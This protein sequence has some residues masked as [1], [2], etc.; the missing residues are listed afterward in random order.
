VSSPEGSGAVFSVQCSVFSVQFSV[1][2]VQ[3]SVF[4]LEG[5]G[6]VF[7]VQCSVFS[8]QCS[9]FSVQCSVFSVQ[10]SVFSVQCSVFSVQPRRFG[11]S[12]EGSGQSQFVCGVELEWVKKKCIGCPYFIS[13]ASNV[14][15]LFTAKE[16]RLRE[17]RNGLSMQR[18]AAVGLF[19]NRKGAKVAR[20]TQGFKFVKNCGRWFFFNRKGAKVT[21]GSQWIKYAKNCG[22]WSFFKPQRSKG[23]AKLAMD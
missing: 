12:L 9:V 23:C 15:F 18:I 16:Q 2:S 3:C 1:F 13:V 20:R 17:V 21:R 11:I 19:L 10:C 8:V 5:S 4:S 22:L 6:A 7:S 14:F